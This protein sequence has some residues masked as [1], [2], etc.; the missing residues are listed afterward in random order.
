MANRT[1]QL[2]KRVESVD[3]MTRNPE[4]GV[5]FK[6]RDDLSL[7]LNMSAFKLR[8]SF[9]WNAGE[10]LTVLE[11]LLDANTDVQYKLAV[12]KFLSEMLGVRLSPVIAVTREAMRVKGDGNIQDKRAISYVTKDI[13]DRPDKIANALA[14]AQFMSGTFKAL[15]PF[16]KRA[17]RDAFEGFNAYT[18]RK[19]K[20]ERRTVK[21]SD[22]I[23]A[24]HPNPRSAEISEL[25]KAII[26][27][28]PEAA[29]EKGT[30]VTEVLSDAS[31]TKAEKKEWID[32]NIGKIPFNALIRNLNSV[33]NTE[34]NERVLDERLKRGL[35]VENGLPVVKVANP[36]DVL[37]A[38]VNTNH[39]EFMEVID[40]RLGEF[41]AGVDLGLANK[42][43]SVLVDVS[44]S[45]GPGYSRYYNQ[46]THVNGIDIVA[47]YISLLLPALRYSDLNMY[48]FNTSVQ[49]MSKHVPLFKRN[50]G[51][52]ITLR[53]LFLDKFSVHGGTSLADAVR[54]V[55]KKDNPELL[56][57]FSDEVSWADRGTNY[58]FD[59]GTSVI[60]INPYP[61][62]KFTVFDPHKP[63]V[64][65]SALDAKIFYYI[66]ILSNFGQ[67]KKWLKDWAFA[68]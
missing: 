29:I 67:F 45:M 50:M 1:F 27:N 12:S 14:Y 28:R 54:K 11:D 61:Q 15:P 68:K 24:L 37:T 60:A 65:L 56:M 6:E 41:M 64:K 47:D 52:P 8:N 20:L 36:F 55:V 40:N 7:F 66:P 44:G 57:V 63:I 4:G 59:V 48:A 31:K 18:L 3:R 42:R 25:Y 13:M 23:K 21:T 33:P 62:G 17:L 22:M 39:T 9:Y 34:D 53:N 5:V 58:V 35:R 30:V 49:D 32:K 2:N 10:T 26:E 38:G 16:Y 51:S 43:V 46:G 19:F